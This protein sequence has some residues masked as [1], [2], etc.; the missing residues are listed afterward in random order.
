MLWEAIT[1][2]SS[3][4]SS[5]APHAEREV[6]DVCGILK[7]LSLNHCIIKDESCWIQ[8]VQ[9]ILVKCPLMTLVFFLNLHPP[10]ENIVTVTV[11]HIPHRSGVSG[12]QWRGDA[13]AGG[14][15]SS[16]YCAGWYCS[17]ATVSHS[18]PP[19]NAPPPPPPPGAAFMSCKEK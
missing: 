17:S 13:R 2:A 9:I 5:R 14:S 8:N 15:L 4:R 11:P 16:S 3:Q 6:E 10:T 19:W 12:W 7:S 1:G 18:N